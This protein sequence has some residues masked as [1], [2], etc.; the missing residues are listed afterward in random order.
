MSLGW[1]QAGVWVLVALV[2][3]LVIFVAGLIWRDGFCRGWRAART[4]SPTCP[5][6]GYDLSGLTQSRCPECGTVY[7]LEELWT[8]PIVRRPTSAP[9]S[10]TPTIVREGQQ[11]V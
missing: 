9:H 3:G 5:K 11:P 1:V 6:C 7:R 8:T 10:T 2:G 4:A